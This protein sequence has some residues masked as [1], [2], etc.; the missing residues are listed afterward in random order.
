M[1]LYCQIY[2]LALVYSLHRLLN[3]WSLKTSVVL[4]RNTEFA[5]SLSF[6]CPLNFYFFKWL[7]LSFFSWASSSSRFFLLAF[8]IFTFDHSITLSMPQMLAQCFEFSCTTLGLVSVLQQSFRFLLCECFLIFHFHE[9]TS[10]IS[11][12]WYSDS[13]YIDSSSWRRWWW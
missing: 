1:L 6:F 8:F 2:K 12:V 3:N 13:R 9:F 10:L 7:V 4:I 5:A 11:D